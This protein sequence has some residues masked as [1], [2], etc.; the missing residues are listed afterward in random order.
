M[1]G[2]VTLAA[3]FVL[4]PEVPERSVLVLIAMVVTVGTLL[5]QGTTLPWLARRLRVRGPDPREDAL[6]EATILQTAVSAGLRALEAI[7]EIDPDT[8]RTVRERAAGRANMAWERLGRGREDEHETPSEAYRRVRLHTLAAERAELLRLRDSGTADQHVLSQVMAALD[9]EESMLDR[10]E[11]R[12][13]E[14]RESMLVSP[15]TAGCAH[16]RRRPVALAP[17]PT[18]ECADCIREGT[19]PVHLRL[20]LSCGNVGCCDSSPGRHAERHYRGTGHEVIRSYEPG[21]AWRWCY[22]DEVLG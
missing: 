2:V 9:V 20:C 21:E 14:L 13:V 17:P 15:E 16:L 10:V 3:A 12:G 11:A 19:V 7:P 6:A 8:A 1:R 5:V 18:R 4:P 22:V